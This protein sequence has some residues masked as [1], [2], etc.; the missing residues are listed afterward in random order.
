MEVDVDVEAGEVVVEVEE[1]LVVG[2]LVTLVEVLELT[3]VVKVVDVADDVEKVVL[4]VAVV[5]VGAPCTKNA[6][7]FQLIDSERRC[8]GTAYA[9]LT[10]R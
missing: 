2:T 5:V 9:T 1:T 6:T 3:V 10:N 7:T 8:G 4:V